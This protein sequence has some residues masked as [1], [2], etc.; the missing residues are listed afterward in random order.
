MKKNKSKPEKDLYDSSDLVLAAKEYNWKLVD[1][2]IA[3]GADPKSTNQ[4]GQN[5]LFFAL[6]RDEIKLADKFYDLGVRLNSLSS[7]AFSTMDL[8]TYELNDILILIAKAS[9]RGRNYFCDE[10]SDLANCCEIQWFERAEK[11]IPMADKEELNRAL[12]VC[13]NQLEVYH[14]DPTMIRLLSHLIDA[15]ADPKRLQIQCLK[16]LRK[17]TSG[18]WSIFG[19]WAALSYT[20]LRDFLEEFEKKYNLTSSATLKLNKHYDKGHFAGINRDQK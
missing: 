18:G 6:V 1:E 3:K 14:K 4:I 2:L 10:N 13:G 11:L 17:M 9:S 20:G 15:G 5:I 8:D 16:V 12:V 19:L 7:L